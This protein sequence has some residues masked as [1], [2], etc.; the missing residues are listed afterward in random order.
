MSGHDDKIDR[1]FAAELEILRLKAAEKARIERATA[2]QQLAMANLQKQHL[3]G[4]TG[5]LG[6][7]LQTASAG[8]YSTVLFPPNPNMGA[9]GPYLNTGLSA[10]L[11]DEALKTQTAWWSG[12]QGIKTERL[13]L[14]ELE[15]THEF[16]DSVLEPDI[17]DQMCRWLNSSDLMKYSRHVSYR[18]D[19]HNAATQRSY[20][21]NTF[22]TRENLLSSMPSR[23]W[24]IFQCDKDREG[25]DSLIGSITGMSYPHGSEK[26]IDIGILLGTMHGNGYA[27]EAMNSVINYFNMKGVTRF[28]CGTHKENEG[29]I[30]LARTL[31]MT[32]ARSDTHYIYFVTTMPSSK[33]QEETVRPVGYVKVT[34]EE[35]EYCRKLGISAEFLA[36]IKRESL[37]EGE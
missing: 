18:E 25:N 11:R 12:K 10:R 17:V 22:G 29:M 32:E 8:T 24:F 21:M 3:A 5:G 13:F 1:Q 2:M 37:G 33:K 20:W 7:A 35:L 19:Y 4:L 15:P 6:N 30:R 16:I 28:T 31:G 27:A 14:L 34:P 26:A 23:Y 36:H 9:Q